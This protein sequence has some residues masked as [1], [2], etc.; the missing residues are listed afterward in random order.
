M[1]LQL[2]Q[3]CTGGG[4]AGRNVKQEAPPVF[5]N[6]IAGEQVTTVKVQLAARKVWRTVGK[7]RR[8]AGNTTPGLLVVTLPTS[9]PQGSIPTDYKMK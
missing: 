4:A 9:F 5:W 3:R 7:D 2:T 6:G 8:T 1:T